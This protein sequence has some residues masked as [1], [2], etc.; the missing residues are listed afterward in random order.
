SLPK[1]ALPFTL[2]PAEV[3]GMDFNSVCVVNGGAV[4]RRITNDRSV[5]AVDMLEKRLAIDKLRVALS[6]PTERLIW[7]DVAPDAPTVMETGFF[8]QS[9]SDLTLR[10]LRA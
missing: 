1:E 3:K 9:L 7:V 10:S 6:R 4:L 5:S 8:L 2:S